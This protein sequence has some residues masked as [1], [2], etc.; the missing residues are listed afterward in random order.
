MS[1]FFLP[2]SFLA[3]LVST[4]GINGCSL[5]TNEHLDVVKNIPLN[6]LHLETGTQLGVNV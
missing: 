3:G 4:I 6:R 2:I 5:R 1:N